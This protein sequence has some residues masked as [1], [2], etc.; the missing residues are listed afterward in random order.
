[1]SEFNEN[2][3]EFLPENSVAENVTE[4][5][6]QTAEPQ[7]FTEGTG[8][9]SGVE[10]VQKKSA[11]KIIAVIVA[12]VVLLFGC[13]AASYA[14]IPQVKNTVKMMMNSPEEYYAWVETENTDDFSWLTEVFEQAE[15][16][17]SVANASIN[18]DS[19]AIEK[20]MAENGAS[21]EEAGM[22]LP[23]SIGMEVK[24][25]E[26][27]GIQS[28]NEIITVGGNPL[29]TYNAY[30]KDGKI[31]YQIPELSSSYICIDFAQMMEM[32]KAEVAAGGDE[33][34]EAFI[35]MIIS[36]AS[37][38][39]SEELV[40]D[41]E[42]RQ[43]LVKYTEILFTSAENVELVKDAACEADGVKC[44]YTKL[45]VNIDE[46]SLFTFAKKAV[47]ELKDEEI[48]IRI[49]EKLGV[50]KEEYQSTI[51]ELAA[52]LGSYEIS[53]G[54]TLCLMN[55]YVNS[56]GEIV[57]RE[58]V[59]AEGAEEPF[60][61]GYVSAND[62]DKYG[63]TAYA[64]IEGQKLSVDGNAT[65][66]SGEFTGEGIISF[67]GQDIF[68]VT[69]KDFAC[70]DEFVKGSVTL[71]LS[72]LELDDMTLNFD[73]KDGKQTL[74]TE[75]TY[76]GTKLFDITMEMSDEKPE[77]ITVFNDAA[78]VYNFTEDGAEL[79]Q[80]AAEINIETFARNC[81][82]ALGL[83]ETY[84]DEF[85]AG[86][87]QGFS[88]SLMGNLGVDEE[89][90]S[91]IGDEYYPEAEEEDPYISDTVEYDF[92][93]IKIQIDG[94]DVTLPG[95]IDGVLDGLDF[96]TDK[97]E[98]NDYGYGFNEDYTVSASVENITDKAL[99]PAECNI[100]SLAVNEEAGIK[101]SVDGFTFGDDVTKVAQKYGA[102]LEDTDYGFFDIAD[103]EEFGYITFFYMDGKIYEIDL[104]F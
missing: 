60:S 95:K 20:L 13:C 89:I 79:E 9:V 66:N 4:P 90:I 19:A 18:L 15:N 75:F 42:L 16:P 2:N 83:D 23:S 3:Q 59:N 65:E 30:V 77:S 41:E 43:F 36:M 7:F 98:A 24:S 6:A 92:S 51:E 68:G 72:A 55:V 11:G 22:K 104:S 70:D 12:I 46:G 39:A 84:V 62:D 45:V 57:G 29:I 99:S 101:L 53:G 67:D 56:K 48:V 64:D 76:Q 78:K 31:Y 49:A 52:Q 44:E 102:T 27:D 103:T 8:V 47:K 40:S 21:F 63:F 86:F 74:G 10:V 33:A 94:K 96:D 50:A 87:E 91:D 28:A 1:M 81:A 69:F 85:I 17:N 54:E 38:E 73:V 34:S 37:G 100:T 80:Y 82:A 25:A 35:D 58:F 5:A 32:S 71:G 93:K 61:I 88:G 97:V 26:I 14:F